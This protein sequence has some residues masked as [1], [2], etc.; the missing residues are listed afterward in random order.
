MKRKH[1]DSFNLAPRL[2]RNRSIFPMPHS[3]LTTFNT[4]VLVPLCAKEIY[5]GDQISEDISVILRGLTPLN[6]V[7]DNA[8]LDVYS[9]F[10]PNRLT[11]SHWEDFISGSAEP[12]EYTA[13][14]EYNVPQITFS[15]LGTASV[16]TTFQNSLLDYM[17]VGYADSSQHIS[18]L[19]PVSAL[20]PRAYVKVWNDW[21]R[22]ENLQQS[23][24][25]YTDD[26][27]RAFQVGQAIETAELGGNLLPISRYHDYFT[28][29]LPAPQKAPPVT[30]PLGLSAP[31]SGYVAPNN[32]VQTHLFSPTWYDSSG[33]VFSR[34]FLLSTSI[35][36]SGSPGLTGVNSSYSGEISGQSTGY[37]DLKV[38]GTADLSDATA[39]SVNSMRLAFQ[40][41]R[42]YEALALSGSRYSES[43]Q[44]LF[45]VYATDSRLQRAELLG[46]KRFPITQHQ[47][48]Q[49]AENADEIGLGT[50]GAFSFTTAKGKLSRKGFPEHGIYLVLACVRTDNTYS[51]GIPV[52]FSRRTKFDYYF[53]TFAH[54]GQ[55]PIYT[56][57]LF[58]SATVSDSTVFGYKEPWAELRTA[59]NSCTSN[60]RP[61]AVNNF[62]MWHYGRKFDSAPVLSPQ[63]IMQSPSEVNRSLAVPATGSQS[64]QW[65]LNAYFDTTMIRVLPRVGYPGL[66]DHH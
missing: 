61:Q 53:P 23:A 19:R 49:T 57:E 62:A 25:M 32:N 13:P 55:Q 45:G 9:F 56:K 4:G 11:W 47:V 3:L 38:N 59:E 33:K 39:I 58:N 52:Q 36:P 1:S 63:F 43:L 42:F 10:V 2:K 26:S 20:F 5:P 66:I 40:T 44:S 18:T 28:S 15:S 31:V 17:G 46:G 6:P 50:T 29:A 21:F 24:H 14:S 16:G 48:A 54:L 41:Q 60:M 37:L 64:V 35:T 8:Y 27:D 34:N 65:L 7:M 22:D 30:L 12:D 51:Q